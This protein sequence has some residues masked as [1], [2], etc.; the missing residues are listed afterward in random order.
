V[1]ASGNVDLV[2]YSASDHGQIVH[3]YA[4]TPGQSTFS[5]FAAK[6]G[7]AFRVRVQPFGASMRTANP[8]RLTAL[9]TPVEDANEP[10]DDNMHAVP[11]AIGS[12][13]SG[14]FFA[15]HEVSTA[16]ALSAWED[17]FKVTLPAGPVTIALTN[18][19]S[20]INSHVILLNPLGAQIA[21]QYTVTYG[22][23]AVIKHTVTPEQA[24]TCFIIVKP[25]G[26]GRTSGSGSTVPTFYTQPYQLLVTTP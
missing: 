8:Y 7:A 26:V 9:F 3:S 5:F 15:G 10:N 20:D 12:P 25:F 16:P 21:N 1:G 19:A 22:S 23:S 11:I 13:V 6:A 14:Y 24:G 17:R 2:V 18:V 4:V